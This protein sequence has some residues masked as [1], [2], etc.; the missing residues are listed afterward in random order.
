MASRPLHRQTGLPVRLRAIALAALSLLVLLPG[1]AALAPT[2]HATSVNPK[3]V[4]VSGPVGTYNTHYKADADAL[5][6]EARKYTKNVVLIKTSHATWSAV[7]SAAQ[8]ASIL[9]YLGHGNGWPSRYRDSLWPFSQNGFGLDPTTGADGSQHV[10]YG[11]SYVASEIRL[12]PNAVVLLFHLCYASGN[13]EPGLST[14]TLADKKARV[15]NYGA[16]F[17]AAGARAVIADSY[18]PNVTYLTRLFTASQTMSS[19]F[20]SVPTY[21]GND[22]A[23]AST[24]TPGARIIMDPT[25]PT[26]GPWY[27]AIVYD[28]R[29]TTG[30]VTR[31]ANPST[32]LV[33]SA[34]VIGGAGFATAA[35]DRFSDAGL[36]S[37]LD[38]LAAG[39][40]LRILA[41]AA[42]L[43]DG[44]RVV[45]VRPIDS[46]VAGYVRAA[47]VSPA[48]STAAKLYNYDRPGALISPNGD[49]VHDT[50]KVIVRASEPL[51]GTI[52]IRDGAGVAVKTSAASQAWSVFGWNLRLPDGSL[53]PDGTYSWSYIGREPW[54]NNSTP[55]SLSGS[56]VL[57]ATSPRTAAAVSGTLHPSSWYTS[58]ATVSLTA[59]DVL[60]G[61]ASR[62]YSLDGGPK[63]RYSGP[64]TIGTSGDHRLGFWS[65]DVAGNVET[66]HI[67]AVRVDRT[68]PSTAAALVGPVGERGFY[69]GDVMISLAASDAE[70]GV[71]S[72]DVSVDGAAL[73]PYLGPFSASAEGA[74]HVAFRSTDRTGHV[75]ASKAVDFKIDLTPPSLGPADAVGPTS[76]QFSPNGDGFA[77]TLSIR[78]DLNEVG[79]VRQVVTGGSTSAV[80]RTMTFNVVQAGPGAI[81]WDGRADGGTVVPDGDYSLTLTP[82]DRAGNAGASWSGSV[83][84]FGAF[85]G[86]SSTPA[87][88]YPQDGDAIRPRT[89]VAFTLRSPAEVE[90]R[91]VNGAG[92]TVRSIVGSYPAGPLTFAW[93]GRNDSGAFVPQGLYRIVVTAVVGDRAETHVKT[94][95]AAA[96][97]LRPSTLTPRRGARFTLTVVTSERLGANPRVTVRQPG[98]TAYRLTLTKIAAATYR[99][100][101]TLRTGGSTGQMTLV[102]SG[103]DTAGG[104]NATSLR[105]PLR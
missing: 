31:T 78:H 54:G 26:R 27:H 42:P 82:F 52:T 103:Y 7:K 55:F 64:F 66:A 29:L 15:D 10:Y 4:I 92:A 28:P 67:L 1:A 74:H 94:V 18:H 98:K 51:D 90:I 16:G 8:G 81:S 62:W 87:R 57:D 102:V 101:W 99:V 84:V 33:P 79:V 72:T 43:P 36:T 35:T 11:E 75:E 44:S 86:L 38:T 53:T 25:D 59:T 61:V 71:L 56:F 21:H 60:S 20:H 6:T 77:D 32:N 50:F 46:D 95:R 5:A 80:V 22:I 12:A 41:E 91:V 48:D 89:V 105:L 9:V 97:E 100:S 73:A 40:R 49:Y 23:W 83:A 14:G 65:T 34:L 39:E 69:R 2:T 3:V 37:P 104:Y 76:G 13:T 63:V 19:L 88:F 24:R 58:A 96:F 45:Q 85:V 68:P 70:S 93:N 17:F 30:M 47:E